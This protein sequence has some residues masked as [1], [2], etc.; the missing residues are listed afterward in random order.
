MSHPDTVLDADGHV[1]ETTEQVAKYLDDPYRRRP[2]AFPVYPADGW[3]RRLLGT[4]GDFGGTAE[5]CKE[6]L[7]PFKQPRRVTILDRLPRSATG[8]VL[9]S[10]LAW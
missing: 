1:T 4:L 7:A 6:R 5:A 8:K 9:K 10:R 3:D 2:L